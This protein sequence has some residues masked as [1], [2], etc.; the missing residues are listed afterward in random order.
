MTTRIRNIFFFFGVIAVVAMFFTLDV[1]LTEMWRSINQAGKWIVA[2]LLLWVGLYLMNALTFRI[3]LKGD[4]T[5]VVP[6]MVLLKLTISGFALNYAT[7]AGLMGGEPY[8]IMELTPYVGRERA[9][10]ITQRMDL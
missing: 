3:I 6:Y 1:S 7:P 5:C 8:K 9:T 2:V 10:S 4:G